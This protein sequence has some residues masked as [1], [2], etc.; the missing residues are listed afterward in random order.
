MNVVRQED[1]AE[2]LEVVFLASFFEDFLKRVA[3][4]FGAEDVGV[5]VATDGDEMEVSSVVGMRPFG[6]VG[7]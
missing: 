3:S 1:V 6:I 2:D 4:G 5:P 7:V